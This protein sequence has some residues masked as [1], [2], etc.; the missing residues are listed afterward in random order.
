MYTLF[1]RSPLFRGMLPADI[2][3]LLQQ[4]TA[5]RKT[6]SKGHTL[7]YR[8]DKCHSLLIILEGTVRGEMADESGKVLTIED[9]NPPQALAPAFLFGEN[10]DYPVN[11]TALTDV[12][13]LQIPRESVLKM[14]QLS[15][16]FLLNFLNF[17]SN[18]ARFLSERLWVLSFKTLREKLGHY[19]LEHSRGT[20]V[21]PIRGTQQ[22]LADYFGV[23]RPSFA[24][25]LGELQSEGIIEVDRK[26]IRILDRKRLLEITR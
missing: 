22:D 7:V 12:V 23:A 13:V 3:L 25:T 4:V 19:L 11:V 20:D 14:M 21:M 9:M 17:M 18:R 1:Q 5:M 6:Y 10:N 26:E 24:R 16:P 2:D 8:G 15:Q